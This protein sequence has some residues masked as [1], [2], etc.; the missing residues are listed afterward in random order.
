MNEGRLY[1]TRIDHKNTRCWWLR[2]PDYSEGA[3]K[4]KFIIQK[5]FPDLRY[6]SKKQA[7]KQAIASRDEWLTMLGIRLDD[8]EAY[9]K[10]LKTK[11]Y[12]YCCTALS[13]NNTSGAIGVTVA[14]KKLK[15]GTHYYYVATAYL[16]KYKTSTKSFSCCKYGP[17]KALTMAI[18]Q[19]KKW[20]KEINK[21]N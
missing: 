6:G 17:A 4:G 8:L 19:R 15:S 11:Q 2:I 9:G 7:L 16:Q 13:K 10:S 12:R 18:A 1:I 20:E 5:S 3:T 14:K 21:E